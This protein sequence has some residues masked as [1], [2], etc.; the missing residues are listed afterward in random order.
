M[1]HPRKVW[2]RAGPWRPTCKRRAQRG[3]ELAPMD[4]DWLR[5]R[6]KVELHCHLDCA[7]RVSTAAEIGRELGLRLPEPLEPALVAPDV[8]A[9]LGDLLSRVHLA[10]EV[11][12]RPQDLARVATEL[13]EDLAADGVVYA[14]VRFAPQLH[15]RRG[16]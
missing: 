14:E 11:M 4:D 10:V 5:S 3:S 9:N 13:V 2:A 16:L 15:T 1:F 7:V 8:C 12:Q 6:S